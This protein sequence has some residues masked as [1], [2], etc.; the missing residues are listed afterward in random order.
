[1]RRFLDL[2]LMAAHHRVVGA[3]RDFFRV[4][5]FTGRVRHVLGNVHQH[6]AG[7]SGAREIEG[8][9]Q[10][11]RKLG[12]VAHEEVVLDAGAGDA[13]G[14]QFLKGVLSDEGCRHLTGD[15]DQRNRIVISGG[16]AGDGVARAGAGG[17][18]RH[19]H[20][21]GAARV[22]VGRVHGGLLMTHEDVTDV[23]L[24]E[25]RVVQEKD[26]AARIPEHVVDLFLLQTPD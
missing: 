12:H 14:V 24:L 1:L 22:A 19:A 15:D 7:T 23:V 10:R 13:D 26:C 25:K 5:E 9:L 20:L 8:F 11:H 2:A 17:D 21:A 4:G 6:R 16:D 18:H 3:H